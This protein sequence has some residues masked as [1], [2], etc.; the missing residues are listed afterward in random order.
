VGERP[1]RAGERGDRA[2]GHRPPGLGAQEE[3]LYAA[4][5]DPV[6]RAAWR[7]TAA[8]LPAAQLVFLDETSASIRLTRATAR[9]V[10]ASPGT[11]AA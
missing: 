6:K 9:A 4:E 2:P 11:T 3:T 8:A 10:A 1:R 7:A 5:Q